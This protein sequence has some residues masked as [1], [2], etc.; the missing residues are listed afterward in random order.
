MKH[1]IIILGVIG[2]LGTFAWGLKWFSDYMEYKYDLTEK[3]ISVINSYSSDHV[4]SAIADYEKTGRASYLLMIGSLL[5]IVAVI[6]MK[7]FG[8]LSALILMVTALSP[9]IFVPRSIAIT[10]ILLLAG[11]LIFILKSEKRGTETNFGNF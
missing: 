10:S 4:N 8:K 7:K 2:S 6:M 1:A 5:S 3:N 9:V 11:I